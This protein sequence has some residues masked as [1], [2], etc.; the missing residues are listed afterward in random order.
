MDQLKQ[1]LVKLTRDDCSSVELS[2]A[3]EPAQCCSASSEQEENVQVADGFDLKR[4]ICTTPG[5]FKSFEKWAST[6]RFKTIVE[7]YQILLFSSLLL[8]GG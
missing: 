8:W 4:P 5:Y 3:N 6:P 2:M 7:T 1:L